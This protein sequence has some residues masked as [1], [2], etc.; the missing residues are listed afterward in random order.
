M[1]IIRLETYISEK[2]LALMDQVVADEN[3]ELAQLGCTAGDYKNWRDYA[4]AMAGT[5][6]SRRVAEFREKCKTAAVGAVVAVVWLSALSSPLSAALLAE[7]GLVSPDPPEASTDFQFGARATDG[8]VG[9]SRVQ[10][11]E[12]PQTVY[13]DAALVADFQAALAGGM[14]SLVFQCVQ[15]YCGDIGQTFG[16]QFEIVIDGPDRN[17]WWGARHAPPLGPGLTG[18]D[19][20]TIERALTATSQTVRIFGEAAPPAGD[21]NGDGLVDAADF[22]VWRKTDGSQA[23][24]A[25]WRAQ[26]GVGGSAAAVAAAA[27][28][29]E[30]G[31]FGMVVLA[32]MGIHWSSRRSSS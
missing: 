1:P 28:V 26:Y 32:L 25:A 10:F 19:I 2:D 22:A 8:T 17:G 6:I 23:G 4:G 3:A 31:N 29:P 15:N 20:T 14:Y 13:A 21:F 16:V 7:L 12:F 5:A 27:A 9:Y 11:S 18:Y 24:Y 30:A